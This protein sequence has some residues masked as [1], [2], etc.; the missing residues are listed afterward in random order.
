MQDVSQ[1]KAYAKADFDLSDDALVR[2]LEK[3]LLSKG[4]SLDAAISILDLGCGPGNI[5]EKLAL[6]FPNAS[7][8]GLDG[9]EAMLAIARERKTN[10]VKQ[11]KLENLNYKFFNITSFVNDDLDSYISGDVV[12]SNSLIH[13]V[14][15][16]TIFWKAAKK[17][18]IPG[19][20]HLHRD[21]RRPKSLKV[22]YELQNLYLPD[23]EPVLINDYIASLKAAFTAKEVKEQLFNEGL[24]KLHVFE[25]MDRYLEV[26]GIY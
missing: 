11:G 17:L 20:I 14:H 6:M 12:V 24:D 1:A 10:Q 23:A 25:I 7:V 8:I 13:H 15:N 4:K 9:S 5:S 19:S 22:V 26:I 3:F 16:P 2:R 18:S 21:L